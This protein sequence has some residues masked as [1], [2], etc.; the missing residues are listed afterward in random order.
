MKK[1][2]T[3]MLIM[4]TFLAIGCEEECES[5]CEVIDATQCSGEKLKICTLKDSCQVWVESSCGAGSI[6]KTEEEVSSCKLEIEGFWNVDN[7]QFTENSCDL[8][9]KK[10][11]RDYYYKVEQ[12]SDIMIE[13][14]SCVGDSSCSYTKNSE[15]EHPFNSI[16][17]ITHNK[18]T[19]L[20]EDF[21]G[22][23]CKLTFDD[24]YSFDFTGKKRTFS[25][26]TK[27]EGIDCEEIKTEIMSQNED[28]AKFFD[29]CIIKTESDLVKE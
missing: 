18:V 29:G 8:S 3:I 7:T 9:D 5:N 4:I 27:S 25:A 16:I 15:G 26:T 21:P 2:L 11:V 1:I 14:F 6:C 23:V 19:D 24:E 20:S 22:K 13:L 28:Y 10:F 17:K 12:K